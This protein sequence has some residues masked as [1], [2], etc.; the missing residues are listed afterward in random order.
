MWTVAQVKIVSP[1]EANESHYY[2]YSLSMN[3][4]LAFQEVAENNLN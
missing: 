4:R 3:D 1:N 2:R